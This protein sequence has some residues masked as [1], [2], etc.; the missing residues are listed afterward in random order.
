M[1]LE[2]STRTG[3]GLRALRVLN[4]QA[5]PVARTDLADTLGTTA[6]YLPQVLAPLIEAGWVDSKPGPNGGYL[7]GKDARALSICELIETMEGPIVDGECIFRDGR[8]DEAAPCVMHVPW[9][10]AREALM[11]ELRSAPAI[12]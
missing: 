2:L 3:L 7:P 9:S 5:D 6:A 4:G 8:C 11:A 12:E 10:R 1:R